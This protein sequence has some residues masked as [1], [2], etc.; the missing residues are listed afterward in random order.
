MAE[1]KEAARDPQDRTVEADLEGKVRR[2]EEYLEDLYL[3]TK[4]F[5]SVTLYDRPAICD[6]L[7]SLAC[8]FVETNVG[9]VLLTEP[10]GVLG[11][12]SLRGALSA[13][14]VLCSEAC[15]FWWKLIDGKVSQAFSR[16]KLREQWDTV[17]AKLADGFAAVGL[18]IRD[19]SLGLLIVGAPHGEGA[20]SQSILSFLTATAGVGS[21][22]IT[23]GDAMRAQKELVETVERSAEAARTEA[24]EKARVLGE[25][26]RKLEIIEQQHHEIRQ[27]STPILDVWGNVIALPIIGRIDAQRSNQIM[28]R[29]LGAVVSNRARYV[30][31]DLTGV[32]TIDTATADHFIRVVR[33]LAMLGARGVVTGIRPAVASTMVQLGVDLTGIATLRSLREG[34][35]ACIGWLASDTM[36]AEPPARR[37]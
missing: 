23:N 33:A 7:L 11:I 26:D 20:F 3:V 27:L 1:E 4:T 13:D 2:L 32:E 5:A 24:A 25:L 22:A 28:E 30:I 31:L 6:T 21:L 37:P 19:E 14:E 16:E 34:L 35:M 36:S 10:G 29:L 15:S 12:A 17:P 8:T 18:A 9:V